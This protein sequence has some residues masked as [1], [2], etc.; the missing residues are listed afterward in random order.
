MFSGCSSLT[1]IDIDLKK[2]HVKNVYQMFYG[3]KKLTSLEMINF[4]MTDIKNY[5]NLFYDC[6]NLE[7]IK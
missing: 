4:N 7:Y 3:C 6:E 1:S 2:A 5:S